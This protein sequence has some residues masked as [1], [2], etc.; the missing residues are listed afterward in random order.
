[1]R[2]VR[3]DAFACAEVF[4]STGLTRNPIALDYSEC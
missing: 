3:L 4:T 1:L 2:F